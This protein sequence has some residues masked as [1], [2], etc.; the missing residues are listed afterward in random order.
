MLVMDNE[1]GLQRS[2]YPDEIIRLCRYEID[3]NG[4]CNIHS[5]VLCVYFFILLCDVDDGARYQCD[6][7]LFFVLSPTPAQL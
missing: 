5:V 6:L 3:C 2:R 4:I 7:E 1:W